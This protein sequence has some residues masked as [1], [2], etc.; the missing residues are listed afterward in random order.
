LKMTNS[1]RASL[2]KP[3]AKP[4]LRASFA[5]SGESAV[6]ILDTSK[7]KFRALVTDIHLVHDKMTGWDVARHAREIDAAFPVV[8]MS[9]ADADAWAAQGVPHSI[10]LPKPFAPAQLVTAVSQLLNVGSPPTALA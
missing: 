5:S 10:M 7:A 8:Y 9:G 2:K 1:F 3:L 4:A 6:E